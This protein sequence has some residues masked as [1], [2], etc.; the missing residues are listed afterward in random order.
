MHPFWLAPGV[1]LDP[2]AN[3]VMNVTLVYWS[4]VS[5]QDVIWSKGNAQFKKLLP[6]SKEQIGNSDGNIECYIYIYT[7]VH[8]I[9]LHGRAVEYTTCLLFTLPRS[10]GR[11]LLGAL[12]A[13]KPQS[14]AFHVEDIPVIQPC[15]FGV[16]SCGIR[17]TKSLQS[18]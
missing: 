3:G 11:S 18:Q 1:C 15:S 17:W 7:Y 14:A 10:N 16:P 4:D 13:S 2:I 9:A 8:K 12:W 6:G 5:G